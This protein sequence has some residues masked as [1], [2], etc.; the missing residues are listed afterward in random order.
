MVKC[1]FLNTNDTDFYLPVIKLALGPWFQPWVDKN[2][3]LINQNIK[4]KYAI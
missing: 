4:V 1:V 2:K 3:K